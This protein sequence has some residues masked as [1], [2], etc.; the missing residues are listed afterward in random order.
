MKIV[1]YILLNTD[2]FWLNKNIFWHHM[3]FYFCNISA[4]ISLEAENW[5]KNFD[6]IIVFRFLDTKLGFLS[7][8]G[9]GRICF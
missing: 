1:K 3:N 5:T 6:K 9:N 8:M 7:F 2:L 4:A